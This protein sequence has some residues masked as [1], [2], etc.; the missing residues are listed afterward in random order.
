MVQLLL[1]KVEDF[2]WIPQIHL[3]R[4]R[5]EASKMLRKIR[6]DHRILM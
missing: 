4:L 5:D 1:L 6:G 3:L 2:L